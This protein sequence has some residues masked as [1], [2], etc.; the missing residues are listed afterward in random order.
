MEKF[1]ILVHLLEKLICSNQVGPDYFWV[2][3]FQVSVPLEGLT[4]QGISFIYSCSH[5]VNLIANLCLISCPSLC[6]R[7]PIH[8][9]GL[10]CKRNIDAGEM[11]IE[12]AG[13]VIRSIQ[14]DK[15]EK[16]YDSKVS[17]T[18]SLSSSFVLL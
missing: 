6:F 4:D 15:R 1:L 13:N 9:R 16:Y 11:V 2:F 3:F 18:L 10:F 5:T 12:Y 14:T 17:L 8:G 7:S